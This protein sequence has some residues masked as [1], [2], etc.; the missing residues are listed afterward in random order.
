MPEVIELREVTD[1]RDVIHRAVQCLSAGELVVLPSEAGSVVAGFTL[2]EAASSVLARND[3][4]A[5]S[6]ILLL[7]SAEEVADYLPQLAPVGLRFARRCWPGPLVIRAA[8]N[9]ESGF[10]SALPLIART[11]LVSNGE[12]SVRVSSHPVLSEVGK[13]LRGPLMIRELTNLPANAEFAQPKWEHVKLVVKEGTATPP[14]TL[15]NPSMPTV[16]TA[17][18]V[19]RINADGWTIE[20][21]G[22]LNEN[23]LQVSACGLIVFVCTGNTC[24]SP[25]AEALFRDMLAKRLNC[26]SLDL[27]KRGY[28][29]ASA[30]LAADYGSQASPES[31]EMMRRRG[32]DLRSHASQPLTDRLLEQADHCYT[33][34]NQHRNLILGGHPE[35]ADRVQLLARDGKDI[36]DPIGG[37]WN[38]YAACAESIEQ[39]LAK[40]LDELL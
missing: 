40:I 22:Q 29:V 1:R 14:I 31:V 35:S 21:I 12:L 17:T 8:A 9:P 13:L 25:M 19:V 23:K 4:D 5:S 3:T 38:H 34:T 24:R 10:L 26:S 39:H 20:R 27:T 15:P 30:G 7:R 6:V 32:L 16:S 2:V 36:S 11:T 37:G 28:I 33:L 18:S